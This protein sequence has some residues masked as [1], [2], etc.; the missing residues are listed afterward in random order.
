VSDQA[1]AGFCVAPFWGSSGRQYIDG[2]TGIVLPAD[3]DSGL[4]YFVDQLIL[5]AHRDNFDLTS[6]AQAYMATDP[7]DSDTWQ[8]IGLAGQNPA[9]VTALGFTTE[10]A[11]DTEVAF[12][13][14]IDQGSS[15]VWGV[16]NSG[17]GG[18]SWGSVTVSGRLFTA[19]N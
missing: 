2:A 10:F 5:C 7:D 14:P 15:L 1:L 4:I 8:P 19:L 16:S 11:W 12:Y 3:T 13:I 18:T 6:F 9:G 17:S